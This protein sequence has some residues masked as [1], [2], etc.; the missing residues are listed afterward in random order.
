MPV[1]SMETI[2]H[3]YFTEFLKKLP[4]FLRSKKWKNEGCF[5]WNVQ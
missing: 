4:V 5:L 2:D 3:F 1:Q